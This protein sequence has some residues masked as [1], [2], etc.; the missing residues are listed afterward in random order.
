MS[1]RLLTAAELARRVEGQ[2][3]RL[4]TSVARAFLAAWERQGIAEE[5]DGGWRLTPAGLA[6][7]SGW[8]VNEPRVSA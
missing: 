1:E 3:L 6:M 4:E 8:D 7:F 2:G 5:R